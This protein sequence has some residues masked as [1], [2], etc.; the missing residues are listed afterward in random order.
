MPADAQLS[1]NGVAAER[2]L[3]F[4]EATEVDAVEG[5]TLGIA[6]R[7]M[8]TA[9]SLPFSSMRRFDFAVSL[10]AGTERERERHPILPTERFDY[11]ALDGA[12]F[13]IDATPLPYRVTSG[14]EALKIAHP[15][16]FQRMDP[17]PCYKTVPA[18]NL[19]AAHAPTAAQINPRFQQIT[20]SA[21]NGY[22]L[23]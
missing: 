10:C 12:G 20:C 11:R 2:L 1:G 16:S 21:E 15:K 5:S 8:L 7:G 14:P 23:V 17:R 22:Q 19:H 3:F 13:A 4:G 18:P 6:Q 9:F